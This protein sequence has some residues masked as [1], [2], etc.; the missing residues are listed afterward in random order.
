[1]TNR[2]NHR[3]SSRQAYV[4]TSRLPRLYKHPAFTC[5]RFRPDRRDDAVPRD[6]Q[7]HAR[8]RSRCTERTNCEMLAEAVRRD[9]SRS[10]LQLAIEIYLQVRLARQDN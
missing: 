1:M 4:S 8:R 6:E 10:H 2:A 3:P 9:R 5:T 7:A